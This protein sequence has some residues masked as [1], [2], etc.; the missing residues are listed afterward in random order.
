MPIVDAEAWLAHYGTPRHSGRYPWG[1]GGNAGAESRRNKTFLDNVAILEKQGMPQKDIAQGLGI[2]MQE[3][4]DGKT[5]A[6]AQQKQEKILRVQ[7]LADKGWGS[8]AI[9]RRTGIP[10]STV[11]SLLKP[12][13]L[14]STKVLDSITNML[15]KEVE[16]KQFVDVGSNVNIGI[17]VSQT[18]FNAA[19]TKLKGDGYNVHTVPLPQVGTSEKTNYKIL[20]APG[21]SQREAYLNRHNIRSIQ[22]KSDDQ[23][24]SFLGIHT[25]ISISSKRVQ[26]RYAED[27]GAESDGMMF[28][29]PG[30]KDVSIGN[31]HYAQV[32][33]A[34]DGTHFLKGMAVYKNDLPDGVDVVFNT[35]KSN[36]GNKLDA[37][38]PLKRKGDGSI[39]EQNPFGATLKV[40]GQIVET[41][42]GKEK[43]TSAMNILNEQGDWEG[44]SKKLSSQI[45]S[46]QSPGLI[47]Q[48]LDMTFEKKAQQFEDIMA[49]TNPTVRRDLLHKF[50]DSADSASVHLKAATLPNSAHHVILPIS[51][52][53]PTEVYAPSLKNGTR[54]AL[55]RSP[56][57]GKFEIPELTV[58][59][60]NKEARE[61]IGTDTTDAIGIHHSVAQRLSG[62]DFDG[63]TVIVI[64]N[65]KGQIK[66]EPALKGLK[67]FDPQHAF[68]PY[69]GMKTIDGGVYNEHTRQADYG[70][71]PDGTAR[72]PAAGNKG[73]E[74]GRITNLIA[75]MSLQGAS[76][77]ELAR[78]VRHSMVVIDAEKHNLNYKESERANNIAQLREKYQG[79][80]QGGASTIIS[81]AGSQARVPNRKPRPAS[82]GGFIDKAT[83]RKMYVPTGEVKLDRNKQPVIDKKTGKPEL[84]TF[85]TK[86]LA[87][88]DDAFQLSSGTKQEALYAEHSNRLKAMANNA[89]KEAIHTQSIPYSDV[90]AKT[91]AKEVASLNS[92]L[93]V[94]LEN[95]PRERQSQVLAR[96]TVAMMKAANPGMD[97]ATEK[98]VKNQ[99]LAEARRRMQSKKERITPTQEEWHA[100]QAGAIS[101]HKLEKILN[102]SD[103]E[104]IRNLAMPKT[105]VKM[106]PIKKSRARTMIASG[107]TQAEVA[108]ALG[109]SLSTL[110]LGLSDG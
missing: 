102:N 16:A 55:V 17:G 62:A 2:T 104:A 23:G 85:V 98:K 107:A 30:V 72:T 11:R 19:L 25:P 46:K 61:L 67:D 64:P 95:T 77:E 68:P 47:K 34:V 18:K 5:I 106:T 76:D 28:V 31:S 14:D 82:E 42:N 110:K 57:G 38:K 70:K 41:V 99:A 71:N 39:D 105:E 43:V 13:A 53:K 32:R 109:V 45:L 8:S 3:L 4:R 101:N 49:L 91:Y 52:M 80:K 51:S 75:D 74:M 54:V 66:S 12:G 7:A 69:H 58:N 59:N 93:N 40:G 94:A 24:R 79:K 65:N 92:K 22:E 6:L 15:K 97:K 83:G 50:A 90:A 33:V 1:S 27:G 56:H 26:V 10:E 48:Q 84:K 103:P 108:D 9:E 96:R 100:I 63:D 21:V 20:V 29:R 86:Q 37:M 78:A 35:N 73:N 44:W 89:R 60:K 87:V 81:R 36:T 88:V